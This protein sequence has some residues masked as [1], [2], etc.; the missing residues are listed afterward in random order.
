MNSARASA[1]SSREGVPGV[2][3]RTP[4]MLTVKVPS[5]PSLTFITQPG[6]EVKTFSQ[7][8]FAFGK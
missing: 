2:F 6:A 5:L 1:G 7:L 3:R 8:G 4:L